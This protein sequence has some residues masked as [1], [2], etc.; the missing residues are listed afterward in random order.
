MHLAIGDEAET[1]SWSS[2]RTPS[3]SASRSLAGKRLEP[4]GGVRCKQFA[5]RVA[6]GLIWWGRGR[7][8]GL[9]VDQRILNRVP[10]VG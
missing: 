1:G 10:R 2:G 6:V 3:A 5:L 4:Y 7:G 8:S 9:Q